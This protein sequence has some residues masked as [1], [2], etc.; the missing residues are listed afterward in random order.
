[1]RYVSN[2]VKFQ[3]LT[4]VHLFAVIY[5]VSKIKNDEL[6]IT[7]A[8]EDRLKNST[9]IANY[10]M[11]VIEKFGTKL[12]NLPDLVEYVLHKMNYHTR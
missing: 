10:S 11:Y 8:V 12:I 9:V 1:M 6:L 7:N 2:K 3:F 5:E 4:R